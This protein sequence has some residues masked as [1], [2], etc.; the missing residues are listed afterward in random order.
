MTEHQG[1]ERV[2]LEPPRGM[3]DFYPADM[4]VRN[5]VF[6]AWVDAA[7]QF[8]FQQY[9][10]CVV[11][12]LP[13]LVR[14]GGEEITNQIYAFQDKSGRDLALR[15]ELTP[16]LARM[17]A[18]REGSLQF[19]LKWFAIAQCF[20]Y[21]RMSR[22]RKREH[23]QW[24]LDIIGEQ[25]VSAEAEVICCALSALD[26][27]GLAEHTQ[28]RFSS[29]ALLGEL[30]TRE[31]IEPEFH[32]AVFMA[33]DKRGKISDDD[34]AA[35]LAEAGLPDASVA[36][37]FRMLAMTDLEQAAAAPDSRALYDIR[38]LLA[39]L[40]A[41]G[42]AGR[43]VFDLSV[44]RGLGYYTGIVFEAFDT[45][46]KL[47]ALFGGGRYDSLLGNLGGTPRSAVG[48]GFGD[49]VVAELMAELGLEAPD[50][51]A[52]CIALGFMEQAQ[53]PSVVRLAAAL[54]RD[55][56]NVDVAL[57]AEKAKHFFARAAKAGFHEAAYVGPDDVEA[58]SIQVKKL[59]DRSQRTLILP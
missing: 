42:M 16:T 32:P 31:G 44:V 46:R 51:A 39:L 48:L 14:K 26:R 47:R 24:N 4:A 5:A 13:L 6:K 7:R 2:S 45:A 56:L 38:A 8:G 57:R 15:P 40:D 22:G 58:G 28:V 11:E 9:D 30:L 1:A 18:A 49:V 35:M 10:S 25:G 36:A 20:R 53:Q 43:V 50:S 34:V 59:S 55:G 23:F 12:S 33:L 37:V 52:N 29:R 54:R 17:V 21:E 3:R 19:P 27:L 41:A